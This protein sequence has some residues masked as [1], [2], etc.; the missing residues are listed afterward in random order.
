MRTVEDE[1]DEDSISISLL[2]G[3]IISI[4]VIK[5]TSVWNGE[6]MEQGWTDVQQAVIV[7]EK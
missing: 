1:V 3:G 5:Q 4:F 6:S 2:C 7:K